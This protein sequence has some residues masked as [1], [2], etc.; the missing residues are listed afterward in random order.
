M[1]S[2]YIYACLAEY[3]RLY[4][5][6]ILRYCIGLVYDVSVHYLKHRIQKELCTLKFRMYGCLDH[7]YSHTCLCTYT[8]ACMYIPAF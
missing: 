2:T 3:S 6:F 8:H 5:V 1:D 7:S 4:I